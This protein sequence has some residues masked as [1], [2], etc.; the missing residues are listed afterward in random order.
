VSAW[1]SVKKIVALKAHALVLAVMILAQVAPLGDGMA[2]ASN[3][4]HHLSMVRHK[5]I[6]TTAAPLASAKGII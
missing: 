4:P 1:H 5:L 6:A 2:L 3:V